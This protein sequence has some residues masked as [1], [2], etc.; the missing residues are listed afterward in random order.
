MGVKEKLGNLNIVI[1]DTLEEG[2]YCFLGWGQ[3][4]LF[5]KDT[6]KLEKVDCKK[7][8]SRLQCLTGGD[9]FI[10]RTLCLAAKDLKRPYDKCG[11]TLVLSKNVYES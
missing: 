8:L 11:N 7:C 5:L 6:F 4:R 9:G 1:L 10:L 2:D 3:T